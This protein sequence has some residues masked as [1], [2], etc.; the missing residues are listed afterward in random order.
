MGEELEL[1]GSRNKCR[2]GQTRRTDQASDRTFCYLS[3][4]RNRKRYDS[5]FLHH[6]DMTAA[7]TRHLP[8][9][10]LKPPDNITATQRWQT[11]HYT[12]TST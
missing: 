11:R 5:A 9:E 10:M 8:S 1:L 2:Y 4:I 7:L 3:V 12:T 6:D